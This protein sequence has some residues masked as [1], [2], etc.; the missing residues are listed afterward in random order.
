M[1][2]TSPGNLTWNSQMFCVQLFTHPIFNPPL[3]PLSFGTVED[4][5]THDHRQGEIEVTHLLMRESYEAPLQ[6]G[7]RSW[8]HKKDR[9][10]HQTQKN[11][12]TMLPPKSLLFIIIDYLTQKTNPENSCYGCFVFFSPSPLAVLPFRSRKCIPR[13]F[14]GLSFQ[15]KIDASPPN[16]KK[17]PPLPPTPQMIFRIPLRF[18]SSYPPKKMLPLK[19]GKNAYKNQNDPQLQNCA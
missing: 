3:F 6:K 9:K 7:Q 18:N 10:G 19:K 16:E 15:K 13:S 11:H 12:T 17:I 5:V 1:Q 2:I 8:V 4:V 14:L